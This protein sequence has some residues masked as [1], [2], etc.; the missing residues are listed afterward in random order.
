MTTVALCNR[1]AASA[2]ASLGRSMRRPLS[3]SVNSLMGFAPPRWK[4]YGLLLRR[5]AEAA[6]A[7]ASRAYAINGDTRHATG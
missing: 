2:S 7:L 1:H 4:G 3:T 6:T 5:N